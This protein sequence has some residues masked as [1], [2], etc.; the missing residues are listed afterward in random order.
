MKKIQYEN[1]SQAIISLASKIEKGKTTKW[2]VKKELENI[3]TKFDSPFLPTQFER[4]TKPWNKEYLKQLRGSV[5]F[6]KSSPDFI[7]YFAEVA[8]YVYRPRRIIKAILIITALVTIVITI[9]S[10]INIQFNISS[11]NI[12][13]LNT[14]S[15]DIL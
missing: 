7:L 3:K 1:S 13:K 11:G 2:A 9:I 5:A 8:D 15:G 4:K 10:M 12:G 6:G 14:H